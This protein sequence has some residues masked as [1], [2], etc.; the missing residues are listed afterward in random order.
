MRNTIVLMLGIIIILLI[1]LS[2]WGGI[3]FA[4]IK[5]KVNSV[6][7]GL[8][9]TQDSIKETIKNINEARNAI[10]EA[11]ESI[12]SA[13]LDL[14]KLNIKLDKEFMDIIRKVKL[15][16]ENKSLLAEKIESIKKDIPGDL[17]VL[18][19]PSYQK[20]GGSK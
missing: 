12:E 7:T 11:K 9:V 2:I 15:L 1:I 8:T 3:N 20:I 14:E 18:R 10:S 16:Q 13:N 5:E 4:E 17:K 19:E 6:N